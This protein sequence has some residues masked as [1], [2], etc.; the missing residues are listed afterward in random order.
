MNIHLKNERQE[1]KTGSFQER[2]LV[3]SRGRMEWV[4]KSKYGRSTSCTCMK[5]EH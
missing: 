4:K 1:Y 5:V 2:V 3:G